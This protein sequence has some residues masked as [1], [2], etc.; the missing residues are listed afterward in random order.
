MKTDADHWSGFDMFGF[1]LIFFG[2]VDFSCPCT[3][4]SDFATIGDAEASP[5]HQ[6]GGLPGSRLAKP[7]VIYLIYLKFIQRFQTP[8]YRHHGV[9]NEKEEVQVPGPFHAGGADGCAVYQRDA[10]LQNPTFGRGRLCH[11]F[12]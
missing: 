12:I 3:E 4:L 1:E 2:L 8:V 5:R 10:L 7:T 9:F 11:V 6:E